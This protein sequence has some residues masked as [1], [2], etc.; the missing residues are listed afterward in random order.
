M[1]QAG[2]IGV[3]HINLAEEQAEQVRQVKKFE[4]G[5]VVNP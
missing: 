5:M 1:A 2:G 4:S 3:I